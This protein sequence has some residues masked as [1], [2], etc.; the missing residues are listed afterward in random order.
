MDYEVLMVSQFTLYG[1]LKG[2]GWLESLICSEIASRLPPCQYQLV[3]LYNMIVST[4]PAKE[5][6]NNFLQMTKKM[7]KS[8]K[9]FDGEFG[10][11][12]HVELVCC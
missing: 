8:E 3:A 9:I 1:S 7:Y 10:A 2:I 12:M 11:Y 5:F 6:Y 4:E